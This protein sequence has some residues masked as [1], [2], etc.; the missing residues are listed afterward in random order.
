MNCFAVLA[1]LT[2]LLVGGALTRSNPAG[3]RNYWYFA[4]ALYAFATTLCFVLYTPPPQK[5]QVEFTNAEKLSKLDWV[6]YFL[7]TSGLVLFCMGLSWA[8]D[9][10]AWTDTHVIVPFLIS[11]AL[12]FGLTFYE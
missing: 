12:T 1:G 9:P 7:L 4:T 6:G 3:F 10:Y 5:V 11:V 2:A 8:Q